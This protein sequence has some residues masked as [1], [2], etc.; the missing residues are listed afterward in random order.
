MKFNVFLLLFKVSKDSKKEYERKMTLNA[1]K[2]RKNANMKQ[3]NCGLI[4]RGTTKIKF[5]KKEN[6]HLNHN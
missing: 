3:I 4:V 6:T 2:R 1:I 5:D